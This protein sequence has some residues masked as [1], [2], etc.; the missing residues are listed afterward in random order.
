MT[1]FINALKN[2]IKKRITELH[3][4][5]IG[6]SLVTLLVICTATFV[7]LPVTYTLISSKNLH[8]QR[9]LLGGSEATLAFNELNL[10][11]GEMSFLPEN[12][13]EDFPGTLIVTDTAGVP[14]FVSR[15]QDIE[16]HGG[17]EILLRD[18]GYEVFHHTLDNG[19]T[20]YYVY[21]SYR[22]ETIA[23]IWI[24]VGY[25]IVFIIVI[26]IVKRKMYDPIAKVE[27]ILHGVIEGETDF[28]FDATKKN[29]PFSPI[30][31]DLHTLF[32][33]MRTLTLRESN[34]QVMK[35]QAE[36]DALQSQ[37][38]PHF[39]YNTLEAIRG[40][41]IEY[42]LQDIEMMT[43]SLS[44]L[45][46]YSISN[47]NTLVTLKEELENVDN[48][49]YIQ[50][51]RFNNKFIKISNVEEDALD[52]LVPKLIIQPIVENAIYH[53][54]EMKI[55]Q[56]RIT[57]SAYITQTRLIINIQDDGLGISEEDLRALNTTLAKGSTKINPHI[58]GSSIGLKNVNARIRLTFGEE[59]GVS[60]YST[61]DVGTD[62]QLKLPLTRE[63]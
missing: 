35:K 24:S 53:G 31:S 36:L 2:N 17:L 63:S 51:L 33:N 12:L 47:H 59:Y 28:T 37:I 52:F 55:G 58:K 13:F 18:D 20:A 45:F 54:L 48:Y 62:V 4:H 38:N 11:L 44:K 19:M 56:G 34:A 42:G 46:R 32:E 14:V 15:M 1:T 49:L 40:Q 9:L 61:K 21:P 26:Y 29:D 23:A 30:F 41:A 8:E 10:R 39:L 57:I 7:I 50:H 60:V 27:R 43:R 25:I 6:A 22:A 5:K 16:Q 3:F